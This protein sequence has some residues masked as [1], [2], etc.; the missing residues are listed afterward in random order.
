[1]T[2]TVN[3]SV[4]C[5]MEKHNPIKMTTVNISVG[6]MENRNPAVH[7]VA[8]AAAVAGKNNSYMPFVAN[9]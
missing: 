8:T 6:C 3:I 9:A 5:I 2:T 7:P 1:M 4:G